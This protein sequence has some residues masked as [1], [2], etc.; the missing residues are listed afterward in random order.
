M[1]N[2]FKDKINKVRNSKNPLENA[3][4]GRRAAFIVLAI[5][6][7]GI[8][9]LM[10]FMTET[11]MGTMRVIL[12]G[13]I[14]VCGAV[15]AFIGYRSRTG[16]NDKADKLAMVKIIGGGI[17]ALCS[18][19]VFFGNAVTALIGL[20]LGGVIIVKSLF[21]LTAAVKV[22][23]FGGGSRG[24]ILF[25][26][27]VI[28]ALIGVYLLLSM[29]GTEPEKRLFVGGILV[30]VEGVLDFVYALLMPYTQKIKDAKN[31]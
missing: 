4:A 19:F 29:G 25:A 10:T 13:L 18:L 27:S 15:L 21:A 26:I 9:A 3:T 16:A 24:G 14:L 30:M 28:T 12:G 17:I 7:C 23:K 1:N 8:G 11:V 20:V 5:V 31:N 6:L 22:M 2:D